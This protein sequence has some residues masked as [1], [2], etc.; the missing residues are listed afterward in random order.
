MKCLSVGPEIIE[1]ETPTIMTELSEDDYSM[2]DCLLQLD[3]QLFSQT[4]LTLE[5][6]KKIAKKAGSSI[7]DLVKISVY[8]KNNSDFFIFKSILSEF[9]PSDKLPAMECIIIPNPAPDYSARIQIE[10]IGYR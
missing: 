3:E 5:M 4:W 6:I 8:L 1:K 7:D 2:Y 9:L 10:A